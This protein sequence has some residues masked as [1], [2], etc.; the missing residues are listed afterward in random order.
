MSSTIRKNSLIMASGTAASRITG[1]I[2]TILLAAAI[3]TTGITANAYQAGS[4]IPQVIYT[5]V[6]GGI[7]NAVLVPQIVRILD[8]EDSKSRLNKLITFAVILLLAITSLM[9]VCTPIITRLYTNGGSEMMALTNAFTLWCMPQIFF[10]GLYTILGQILAAKNHFIT[11]AWSSVGAN[12]ISIIGFGIFLLLFGNSTYQP[13]SFWTNDKILLIAGAWTLGVA[14]QALILF[15]P[16]KKIGFKYKP[17]FGI[18]GFGLRSM[19][20]V[21]AWSLG[22]VVI[23]QIATIIITRIA[24]NAPETAKQV[25]NI[26]PYSVAGNASYQNAFTIYILPYSLV[27]VSVAT[28]VFPI[29][30]K[31]IADH[32]LIKAS[33]HLSESLRSVALIMTYFAIVCAT[34]PVVIIK[35]LLPSVSGNAIELIADPLVAFTIMLPIAGMYVLLQRTFYAFEDGKSPFL[36]EAAQTIVSI[37]AMLVGTQF[38]HP[39]YWVTYIAATYTVTH[40]VCFPFLF[41][42]L[43]KHFKQDFNI[44]ATVQTFAKIIIAAIVAIFIVLLAKQPVLHLLGSAT[45]GSYS[46]IKWGH[47]ILASIIISVLALIVY[48]LMLLVLRTPELIQIVDIASRKLHIK[49][50]NWIIRILDTQKS[51][52]FNQ[53]ATQKTRTVSSS[54]NPARLHQRVV[55]STLHSAKNTSSNTSNNAKNQSSIDLQNEQSGHPA[56]LSTQLVQLKRNGTFVHALKENETLANNPKSNTAIPVGNNNDVNSQ[57]PSDIKQNDKTHNSSEP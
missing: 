38:I 9:A 41:V 47:S 24:S 51:A 57:N 40:I 49:L 17:E 29:M 30:S 33:T 50:P 12:I 5:L 18:S 39:T 31:A 7:F 37:I 27:A 15:Y 23:N 6:S 10:Y 54:I 35:A 48:T 22:I 21:A 53:A 44:F 26:D 3:G 52:G 34:I 45:T 13:V 32:D 28:S 55:S 46:N 4:M 56:E 20:P 11:Y 43:R 19:G 2:R 42:Q 14:F 1:Q 36:F 16:L 8:K 25:W